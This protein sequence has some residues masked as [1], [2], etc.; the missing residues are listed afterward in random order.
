MQNKHIRLSEDL[1][2]RIEQE[3]RKDGLRTE[4]DMIRRLLD[5]ALTYRETLSVASSPR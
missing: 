3:R 5:E 4:V 2:A 1:V